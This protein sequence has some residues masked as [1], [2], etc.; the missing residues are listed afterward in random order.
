MKRF[1]RLRALTTLTVATASMAAL[2]CPPRLAADQQKQAEES[3]SRNSQVRPLP[4]RLDNVLMLNDNNPELITGE[5]ILVSTFPSGPG[6]NVTLNGRFDLFSHHVYAG[7]PE[8]LN[9][10]LWIGVVASPR[11]DRPVKLRV[12]RGST[13]LS[14]SLDNS[15]LKRL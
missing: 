9:S 3:L 2:L 13:A 15:L 12:L 14:Q 7:K 11:G 4:G 8:T 5:G 6:L 10:T 1:H